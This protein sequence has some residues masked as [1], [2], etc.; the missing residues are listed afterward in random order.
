MQVMTLHH[1][2]KHGLSTSLFRQSKHLLLLCIQEHAF[3]PESTAFMGVYCFFHSYFSLAFLPITHK[4]FLEAVSIIQG[5]L[6][7]NISDRLCASVIGDMVLYL[8]ATYYRILQAKSYYG[9]NKERATI[10]PAMLRGNLIYICSKYYHYVI[11]RTQSTQ[12]SSH[13]VLYSS[14]SH[15]PHVH[16][17][18]HSCDLLYHHSFDSMYHCQCKQKGTLL[19][20]N[21][22]CGWERAGAFV[23]TYL[24]HYSSPSLLH[25]VLLAMLICKC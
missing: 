19:R 21:L 20:K 6:Q 7:I 18:V 5:E 22:C 2:Y 13:R 23:P 9:N 15:P 8:P 10:G 16:T 4:C 14:H 17:H 12:T 24:N 11:M 25:M 3:M 1:K